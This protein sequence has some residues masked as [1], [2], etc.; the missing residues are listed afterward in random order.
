VVTSAAGVAAGL[1]SGAPHAARNTIAAT[2]VGARRI[3][4]LGLAFGVS[5]VRRVRMR[6]SSVVP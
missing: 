4:G 1:G 6:A 2:A 3:T 5:Q